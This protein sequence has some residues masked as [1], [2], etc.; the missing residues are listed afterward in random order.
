MKPAKRSVSPRSSP[1][2]TRSTSPAAKSEEKRMFSQANENV[3]YWYSNCLFIPYLGHCA[4]L[5]AI[6]NKSATDPR[7]S[8]KPWLV[9]IDDDTIMRWFNMELQYWT[10]QMEYLEPPS[11]QIKDE[12]WLS[13]G[14]IFD[15]GGDWGLLFHFILSKI[16]IGHNRWKI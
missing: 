16:N 8:D 10:K 2:E 15:F 11:P 12:F 7:A 13:L 3:S 6:I 9:V 4:K 14:F 1:L 5:Q